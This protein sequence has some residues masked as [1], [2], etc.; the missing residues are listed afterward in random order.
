[1]AVPPRHVLRLSEFL[2]TQ[3]AYFLPWQ[4]EEVTSGG[5]VGGLPREREEGEGCFPGHELLGSPLAAG[6][7][8]R[9]G[10][11][12]KRFPRALPETRH[13]LTKVGEVWFTSVSVPALFWIRDSDRF[14]HLFISGSATW[15]ACHSQVLS[16]W[17]LFRGVPQGEGTFS[18]TCHSIHPPRHPLLVETGKKEKKNLD[19]IQI[20]ENAS[21]LPP[22]HVIC[23]MWHDS[24]LLWSES[25][26]F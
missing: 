21:S 18:L 3:L 2:A 1:M 7:C 11:G 4:V 12:L 19:F 26:R 8:R 13:H 9:G 20:W 6:C 22:I 17:L 16:L 25:P 15:S 5:L 24:V 10:R 23:G 14:K